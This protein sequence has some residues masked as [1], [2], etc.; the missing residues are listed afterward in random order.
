MLLSWLHGASMYFIGVRISLS[1]SR[2]TLRLFRFPSAPFVRASQRRRVALRG[3]GV[4][5]QRQ[6]EQEQHAQQHE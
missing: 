2:V 3:L 1:L 6:D 4:G 5:V